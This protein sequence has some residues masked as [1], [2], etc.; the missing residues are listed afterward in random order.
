MEETMMGFVMAVIWK[1]VK[2]GRVCAGTCILLSLH[3]S[4]LS[5]AIK[6]QHH[7]HFK[8]VNS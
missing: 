8:I 6:I 5:V 3:S 7:F 4:E 2:S 1:V